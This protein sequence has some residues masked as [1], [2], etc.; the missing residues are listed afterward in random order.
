[1]GIYPEQS[2]AK[3]PEDA[4][5]CSLAAALVK[6]DLFINSTVATLAGQLLWQLLRKGRLTHHGYIVNLATGTTLP[7]PV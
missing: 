3:D 5:S 1:M 7:L 2:L 4:P 6:Q